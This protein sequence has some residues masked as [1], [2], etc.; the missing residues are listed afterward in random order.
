MNTDTLIRGWG[1][2]ELADMLGVALDD[3][4]ADFGEIHRA[5]DKLVVGS[6]PVDEARGACE[7]IRK[8]LKK[9]AEEDRGFMEPFY[10]G[11]ASVE[12]DWTLLRLVAR[13]LGILWT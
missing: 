9:L 12:D 1:E 11:M 3:D 6:E 7:W 4:H 5:L 2:G 13:N 10:L 8:W